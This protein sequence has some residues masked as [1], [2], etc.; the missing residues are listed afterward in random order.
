M[1]AQTDVKYIFL[2]LVYLKWYTDNK[3]VI[4]IL[5]TGSRK[6][7][8]Q[9]IAVNIQELCRAKSSNVLPVWISRDQNQIADDLSKTL[10]C[11]DCCVSNDM[12]F[13]N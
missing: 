7:D 2:Y 4:Y 1:L 5:Q 12:F 9:I 8:L 10:D 13:A 6:L 3:N 11:D